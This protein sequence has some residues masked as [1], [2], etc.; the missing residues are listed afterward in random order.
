MAENSQFDVPIL[1]FIASGYQDTASALAESSRTEIATKKNLQEQQQIYSNIATLQEQRAQDQRI[2][3]EATISAEQRTE[4]GKAAIAN[5]LGITQPGGMSDEILRL[6]DKTLQSGREVEAKLAEL[7]RARNSAF[8]DN[9]VQFIIDGIS[10]GYKM[11]DVE[12]AARKA[13]FYSNQLGTLHTVTQKA[14][15]VYTGTNR[16]LSKTVADAAIRQA[17]FEAQLAVESANLA[18]LKTNADEIETSL[19]ASKER[20]SMQFTAENMRKQQAAESRADEMLKLHKEQFEFSKEERRLATIAKTEGKDIDDYLVETIALGYNGRTGQKLTEAALK[21]K[22]A[23]F[24]RGG[25]GAEEIR[26]DYEAGE[27]VRMTGKY[28]LGAT[29]ADAII[30]L[31]SQPVEITEAQEQIKNVLARARAKLNAPLIK[32]AD[33]TVIDKKDPVAVR[34]FINTEVARDIKQ[35]RDAILAHQS[36]IFHVGDIST[37]IAKSP[38]LQELPITKKLFDPLIRTNVPL[39]DPGNLLG[40][41]VEKVS[42]GDLSLSEA[43]DGLASIYERASLMNLATKDPY[44]FGIRTKDLFGDGE[45]RRYNAVIDSGGRTLDMTD[46]VA[47]GTELSKR[48]ARKVYGEQFKRFRDTGQLK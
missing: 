22:L 15:E 6:V 27:R 38:Q 11:R 30:T 46:R 18:R 33:G 47:I 5:T 48:L 41:T 39:H 26:K 1:T 14:T 17:G 36:N 19:K 29:P 2:V 37:Y 8:K 25:P 43:V 20:I 44:K 35:Q 7:D 4:A 45:K 9:P 23:I 31:E 32:G 21:S 42:S 12:D 40:L 16:V 13:E 10:R 24:R 3:K 28:S 34:D